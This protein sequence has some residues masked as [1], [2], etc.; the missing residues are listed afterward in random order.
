M[1]NTLT[2]YAR[3]ACR[4]CP[5]LTYTDTASVNSKLMER[6]LLGGC[7]AGADADWAH[8]EGDRCHHLGLL[9]GRQ[10]LP[11][12]RAEDGDAMAQQLWVWSQLPAPPYE[13]RH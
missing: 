8:Q 11:L 5:T 10:G 7:W 2:L 12:Q 4:S 3:T 6:T 1:G 9:Q 13:V